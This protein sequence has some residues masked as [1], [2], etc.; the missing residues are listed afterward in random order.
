MDHNTPVGSSHISN[1]NEEIRNRSLIKNDQI[2][3]TSASVP[4]ISLADKSKAEI[5][6][7]SVTDEK[8]KLEI[9]ND[10]HEQNAK[11]PKS[12][13][14]TGLSLKDKFK[15]QM[16]KNAS[17]LT[18]TRGILGQLR[19]EV[20]SR[21]RNEAAQIHV[22]GTDVDIGPFY[23]LPSKVEHLL[24]AHRGITKLYG[25]MTFV[26]F[27]LLILSLLVMVMYINILNSIVVI[28]IIIVIF[29]TVLL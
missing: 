20:M 23:G 21:A 25:L 22:K 26:L 6:V 9:K 2:S 3:V 13:S 14:G 11:T 16:Q 28:C 5:H 24:K 18:P 1:E 15:K 12:V 19:E 10:F 27:S 8:N 17:E 4:E 7:N 29:K